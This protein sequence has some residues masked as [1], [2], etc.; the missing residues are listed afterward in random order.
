MVNPKLK[1]QAR[2]SSE[3][4]AAPGLSTPAA[5]LCAGEARPR[6]AKPCR[7][8]ALIQAIQHNRPGLPSVRNLEYQEGLRGPSYTDNAL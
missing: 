4:F 2:H 1:N 7:L 8:Y 5:V 6:R 3:T